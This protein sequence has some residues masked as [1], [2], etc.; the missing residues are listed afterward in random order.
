MINL[1]ERQINQMLTDRVD[2]RHRGL[3]EQ[4]GC[5]N[6]DH[7]L[8]TVADRMGNRGHPRKDHV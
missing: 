6:D 2:W 1:R 4:N 8:D 7:T 3:E 5:N